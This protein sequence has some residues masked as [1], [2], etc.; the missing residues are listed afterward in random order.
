MRVL[1]TA[2]ALALTLSLSGCA[3]MKP[4]NDISDYMF[5]AFRPKGLDYQMSA[6]QA[7][8]EWDQVAIEGRGE[9]PRATNKDPLY[10]IDSPKHREIK[11]NLGYTD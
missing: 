1:R 6:D 11:R 8:G 3:L 9:R 2:A 5:S 7:T 10:W 4:V